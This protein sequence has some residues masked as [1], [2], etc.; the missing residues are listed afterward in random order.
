MN[1]VILI[2][3]VAVML[4]GGGAAPSAER[5][6][7]AIKVE[8]SL[9][10]SAYLPGDPVAVTMRVTNVSAAP[11]VLTTRGQQYDVIVRQRGALVWQW[12]HDK[13]FAQ[14]IQEFR[15][16]PSEMRTFQVTWDQRDLQ[17]RSV[18]AGGYEISGVYMGA[19][20]SGPRTVD[21][22]PVRIVIGR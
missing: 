13:G 4:A 17:G 7:G 18:E 21:I 19:Q 14:V 3:I 10:K 6:T 5:I 20:P 16:A 9:A 2:L 1:S 15:L 12:S 11:V 8:I 22:G